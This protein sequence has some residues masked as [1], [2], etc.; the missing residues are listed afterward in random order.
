[1]MSIFLS[2][3]LDCIFYFHSLMRLIRLYA[4]DGTRAIVGGWGASLLYPLS[5]ANGVIRVRA[6]CTLLFTLEVNP[7]GKRHVF[8]IFTK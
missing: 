5:V 3:T 7:H 1:M 8:L 2:S 4:N 6:L